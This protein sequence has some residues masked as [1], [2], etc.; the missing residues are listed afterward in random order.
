M[1]LHRVND[2]EHNI[3]PDIY[4]DMEGI[5]VMPPWYCISKKQEG[6]CTDK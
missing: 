3:K 1:F 5:S 2:I 6:K 4:T